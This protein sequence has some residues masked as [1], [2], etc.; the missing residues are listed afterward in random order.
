MKTRG[1][2]SKSRGVPGPRLPGSPGAGAD[3]P[4]PTQVGRQFFNGNFPA[5]VDDFRVRYSIRPDP[6]GTERTAFYAAEMF[7]F[8]NRKAHGF[9]SA[10][11]LRR[12]F[13][14]FGV[15]SNT[16]SH[17]ATGFSQKFSNVRNGPFP[18]RYTGSS[19][20]PSPYGCARVRI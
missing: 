2:N 10:V 16:T 18:L 12:R 20:S 6:N 4:K 13:L 8:E 9:D 19:A 17:S 3:R 1:G 14:V 5:P 15:R 7:S 11:S